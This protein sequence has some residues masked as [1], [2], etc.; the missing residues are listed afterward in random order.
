VCLYPRIPS[1][2]FAF[3]VVFFPKYPQI[4]EDRAN[5]GVNPYITYLQRPTTTIVHMVVPLFPAVTTEYQRGWLMAI[6][7]RSRFGKYQPTAAPFGN[8]LC[9]AKC[10]SKLI[11]WL[12]KLVPYVVKVVPNCKKLFCSNPKLIMHNKLLYLE[13]WT[14]E[15]HVEVE[16]RRE[17]MISLITLRFTHISEPFNHKTCLLYLILSSVIPTFYII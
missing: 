14:G 7:A 5:K 17:N 11:F 13:P 6:G 1:V 2:F 16:V 10:R 8:P 3:S 9:V 4:C 12:L 15:I